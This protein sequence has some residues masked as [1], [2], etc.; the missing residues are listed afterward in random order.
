MIG[1]VILHELQFQRRFK[2]QPTKALLQLCCMWTDL[3]F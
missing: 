1:P 2:A 3:K